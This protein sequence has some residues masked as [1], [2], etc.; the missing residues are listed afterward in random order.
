VY[1]CPWLG[2]RGHGVELTW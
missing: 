1:P 2:V